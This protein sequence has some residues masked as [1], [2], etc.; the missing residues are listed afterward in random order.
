[1]KEDSSTNPANKFAP[2]QIIKNKLQIISKLQEKKIGDQERL[3]AIKE[4]LLSGET[5]TF[6]DNNYL[7]TQYEEYKKVS[8][9]ESEK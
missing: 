3:E 2:N 1:M 4:S 6:T 8:K 5:F 9:E 7:E